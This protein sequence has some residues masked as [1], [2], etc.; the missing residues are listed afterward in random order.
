MTDLPVKRKVGRPKGSR[1]AERVLK[2]QKIQQIINLS[3]N[4]LIRVLRGETNLPL[5]TVVNVAL[6]LYKRRIPTKV[7]N[8]GKAGQL[9]LIKIVKNHVPEKIDTVDI[10]EEAV[11]GVL[12]KQEPGEIERALARSSN[13]SQVRTTLEEEEKEEF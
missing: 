2:A 8:E 11:D 1:S 3:E 4:Q 6:E 10:L 13:E 12:R 7:E 9:T 5:K